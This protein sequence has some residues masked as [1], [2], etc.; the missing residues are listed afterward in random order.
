MDFNEL[1]TLYKRASLAPT[2]AK[3]EL[4]DYEFDGKIEFSNAPTFVMNL[5]HLVVMHTFIENK[6]DVY[7]KSDDNM[8]PINNDDIHFLQV[9]SYQLGPNNS[10]QDFFNE[11]KYAKCIVFYASPNAGSIFHEGYK[12]RAAVITDELIQSKI[13]ERVYN[14][15]K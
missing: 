2:I 8:L 6:E 4:R 10:L 1:F 13:K 9:T 12:I 11:N 7:I 5:E 3:R 15:E 14:A